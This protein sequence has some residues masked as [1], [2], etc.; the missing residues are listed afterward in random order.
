MKSRSQ[1]SVSSTTLYR[2]NVTTKQLSDGGFGLAIATKIAT[3]IFDYLQSLDPSSDAATDKG[4][5]VDIRKKISSAAE[6]T[7]PANVSVLR[8]CP[9]HAAVNS[10]ADSNRELVSETHTSLNTALKAH[11]KWPGAFMQLRE[12]NNEGILEAMRNL[13]VEVEYGVL[14]WFFVYAPGH[15]QKT[16]KKSSGC[17]SPRREIHTKMGGL[18][19]GCESVVAHDSST[20]VPKKV[21]VGRIT[22]SHT[23]SELTHYA[24]PLCRRIVELI[25]STRAGRDITKCIEPSAHYSCRWDRTNGPRR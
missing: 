3:A 7:K 9:L 22:L 4:G 25:A 18:H 20:C 19:Q 17:S 16:R 8:S 24:H 21:H 12:V 23:A 1:K 10:L 6:D 11:S 5:E 15:T 2:V 14:V 13:G